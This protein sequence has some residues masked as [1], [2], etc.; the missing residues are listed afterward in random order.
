VTIAFTIQSFDMAKNQKGSTPQHR[1][2]TNQRNQNTSQGKRKNGSKQ[3][4]PKT[5]VPPQTNSTPSNRHSSP[6]NDSI[7][8][9]LAAALDDSSNGQDC[10]A[11]SSENGNVDETAVQIAEASDDHSSVI[12]RND[13]LVPKKTEETKPI[14][15]SKNWTAD[16]PR[17]HIHIVSNIFTIVSL[18]PTAYPQGKSVSCRR[19]CFP[20]V[21]F[22]EDSFRRI[23]PA[24][25]TLCQLC[26]WTRHGERILFSRTDGGETRQTRGRFKE[27]DD[28][29]R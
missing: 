21:C 11:R 8:R 9:N 15:V 7:K 28:G 16:V 29:S 2:I 24:A 18:P 26:S 19:R 13:R 22:V 14:K 12:D 17:H 4:A 5:P 23:P 25:F 1:G 6:F 20:M 10:I 3:N 27:V